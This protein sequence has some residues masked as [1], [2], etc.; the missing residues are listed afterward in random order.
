MTLRHTCWLCCALPGQYFHP[1]SALAAICANYQRVFMRFIVA[2][3]LVMGVSLFAAD[4]TRDFGQV[5]A[6]RVFGEVTVIDEENG[7]ETPL[8][9]N[10]Q[11]YEGYTV[12][13][14]AQASVIL[15]F[16]NGASVRV[17]PNT[18]LAL[19]VFR[20]DPLGKEVEAASLATEPTASETKLDLVYGE[21]VGDVSKLRTSTSYNIKTAVGS[22]GIRGTKFRLFNREVEG[23]E[24]QF[25][26][27]THEGIVH[28]GDD[29]GR[30]GVDVSAGKELGGRFRSG[31]KPPFTHARLRVI[32]PRAKTLIEHVT[33]IMHEAARHVRFRP[34]EK[35]G[36]PGQRPKLH[37][38]P[39]QQREKTNDLKD[40]SKDDPEWN[41]TNAART[42]SIPKPKRGK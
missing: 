21:M 29:S 39:A 25:A 6:A 15:L 3:F 27:S 26:L 4:S 16:S 10:D 41:H 24:Q 40:L 11:L 8:H 42:P 34:L 22:A 17:M 9:N 32:S 33:P 37:R 36:A 14:Q 13:T 31:L 35:K 23:G 7:T 28:M 2:L 12:V 18:R 30:G 19:D 1:A 20:Q 38:D 5:V